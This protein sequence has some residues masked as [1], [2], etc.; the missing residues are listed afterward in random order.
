MVVGLLPDTTAGGIVQSLYL[1]KNIVNME[2]FGFVCKIFSYETKTGFVT[3]ERTDE[4]EV[5]D[6]RIRTGSCKKVVN[7]TD[8]YGCPHGLFFIGSVIF[9]QAV[10]AI[11]RKKA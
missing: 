11:K 3:P 1:P 6:C 2:N 9:Y 8:D 4:G 5:A 10:P 7:D